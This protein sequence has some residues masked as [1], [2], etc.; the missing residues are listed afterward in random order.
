MILMTPKDDVVTAFA[1]GW[2]EQEP[3]IMVLSPTTHRGVQFCS[4]Q[5]AGAPDR[6]NDE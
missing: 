3:H 1:T 6:E 5:G 4:Y 2:P